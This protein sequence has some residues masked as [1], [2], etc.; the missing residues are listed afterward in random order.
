MARKCRWF[1]SLTAGMGMLAAAGPRPAAS[2][3]PPD[4]TI[5]AQGGSVL[6]DE[7]VRIVVVDSTG[8][9]EVCQ[10]DP[11]DRDTG[12][13]TSTTPVVLTS[14]DM[15]S[16][17]TAVQTAGFFALAPDHASSIPDG[18]Y[19]ELTIRGGGASHTVRTQNLEVLGFDLVLAALNA[20]L[21]PGLG[22]ETNELHPD[23]P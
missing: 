8:S 20:A 21:P 14:Q 10:V 4:M 13:C 11:P 16:V 5:I 15:D 2:Q 18:T 7:P 1:L 22:I 3:A 6:P 23:A 9:G 12:A 19:A 17:W